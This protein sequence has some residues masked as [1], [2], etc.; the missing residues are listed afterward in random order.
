MRVCVAARLLF[1]LF[2]DK[3]R[4]NNL[5]RTIEVWDVGTSELLKLLVLSEREELG[6]RAKAFG[7]SISFSL[8]MIQAY[9][10]CLGR[11]R[12]DASLSLECD[13]RRLVRQKVAHNQ[14]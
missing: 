4:E 14:Q 9:G 7:S 11:V 10:S 13:A 5:L 8:C 3:T 12:H 2:P 6:V 1:S